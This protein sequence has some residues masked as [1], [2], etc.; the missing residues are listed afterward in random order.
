[1]D[2]HEANLLA[3]NRPDTISGIRVL[4]LNCLQ[5]LEPRSQ[6]DAMVLSPVYNN[7]SV[8]QDLGNLPSDCASYHVSP[9][10]IQEILNDALVVRRHCPDE[11]YVIWS[12]SVE[13]HPIFQ[14]FPK[15]WVNPVYRGAYYKAL[16][17][18]LYNAYNSPAIVVY[19]LLYVQQVVF[20]NAAGVA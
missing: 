1:M 7:L 19:C 18:V 20:T 11:I 17:D 13:S 5:E 15:L 6:L 3:S 4:D 2:N 9:P 10:V 12:R 14:M 16:F 8:V